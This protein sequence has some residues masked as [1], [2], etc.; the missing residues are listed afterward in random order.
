MTKQRA[1]DILKNHNNYSFTQI[2]EAIKFLMSVGF[3][4]N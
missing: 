3:K 1:L 2:N 4:V